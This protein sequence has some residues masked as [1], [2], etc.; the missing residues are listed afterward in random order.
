MSINEHNVNTGLVSLLFY[1]LNLEEIICFPT[2]F[3]LFS[4][5]F[6]YSWPRTIR[7]EPKKSEASG[8]KWP[9]VQ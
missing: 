5:V 7:P 6:I 3:R 1:R 8:I 2:D 9:D 4:S